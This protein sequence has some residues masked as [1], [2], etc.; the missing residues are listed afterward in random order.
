VGIDALLYL[1]HKCDT[2]DQP[3]LSARFAKNQSRLFMGSLG[4][5]GLEVRVSIRVWRIQF[6]AVSLDAAD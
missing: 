4:Q 2:H 3:C 6:V 1:P 5:K